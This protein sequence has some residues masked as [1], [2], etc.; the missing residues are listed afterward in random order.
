MLSVAVV[1]V[2]QMLDIGILTLEKA[3]TVPI[4]IAAHSR[5]SKLEQLRF[6]EIL[7]P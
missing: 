5:I 2:H 1:Y 3:L 6:L 4:F 7:G